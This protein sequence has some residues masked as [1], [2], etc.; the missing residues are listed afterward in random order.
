MKLSEV[1]VNTTSAESYMRKLG[2]H[3]SHRFPVAFSENK[4]CSIEM[5]NGTC[6]LHAE[7]ERLQIRLTSAPKA[8]RTAS[9][10]SSRN[11]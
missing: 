1:I 7:S 10:R 4:S 9:R 6:E 8:I 3:W 2:Q 5:P 11:I